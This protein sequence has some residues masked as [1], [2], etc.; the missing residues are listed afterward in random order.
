MAKP[1][2]YVRTGFMDTQDG[3][4]PHSSEWRGSSGRPS[5]KPARG[6]PACAGRSCRRATAGAA[7][8]A[9]PG[10][11]SACRQRLALDLDRP[12]PSAPSSTRSASSSPTST[13]V[14]WGALLLGLAF[15][16]LNLT[17][18]SRALLQ[19]PARRLPG[20]GYQ[21]RRIW[22][23]YFAAVGF[24][25]V[26]PGARRRHHQAVPR[27]LLGPGLELSDGRRR[28]LRGVDV[29]RQRRRARADL[30][31]HAGRL[32]KAAGLLQARARS[33]SPTWLRTFAS[34]CS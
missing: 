5:T 34:R 29:R 1:G 18:R 33:T 21:W 6:R 32:P 3:R 28:V 13:A 23:A 20:L 24:N 16:G 9:S 25:N 26:V 27:A 8:R 31:V 22:G 17:L 15:F 11:L 19:Q 30:R 2:I 10:R 7:P 4:Q 12:Q 14:H